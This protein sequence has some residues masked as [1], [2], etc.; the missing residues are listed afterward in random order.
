MKAA[1]LYCLA[2][3]ACSGM[4]AGQT[5][6]PGTTAGQRVLV[7]HKNTGEVMVDL[8]VTDGHGHIVRRL[9]PDE[10]EV[11]DNGRRQPIVS[12]RQVTHSVDLTGSELRRKGLRAALRP[13]PFNLTVMVFDRLGNYGRILARNAARFYIEKEMG[14]RDYTAVYNIQHVLLALQTFTTDKAKLLQAVQAA[15]NS[16]HGS[17]GSGES[18]AAENLQ[19]Q[20]VAEEASATQALTGVG[21]GG[22]PPGAVGGLVQA[23]MDAMMADMLQGAAAMKVEDQSWASLTALESIVRVLGQLPGRKE[24]LY[25]SQNIAVNTN[26]GFVFRNLVR[27]ANRNHVSI[28]SIDT[29]GLTTNFTMAGGM[30]EGSNPSTLTTCLTCSSEARSLNYS[31]QVSQQ[32]TRSG[33]RGKVT[34]AEAKA[35]EAMQNI[36]Y[37]D[38][39]NSMWAL[40][41]STGGFLA[42]YT[43]NLTPYMREAGEDMHAHYELSY[44]P[45]GGLNGA[46]HTIAIRVPGHPG[47]H[48]RAR[49]GYY[50][51]PQLAS[52]VDDYA[53]PALALLESH[54]PASALPLETGNFEFPANSTLPRVS[55]LTTIPLAGLKGFPPS[56]AEIARD[57][58]LRGKQLVRLV[59]LQVIRDAKQ[60]VLQNFSQQYEWS[61]SGR[62]MAELLRKNVVFS[63]STR[64]P[65]GDYE[66]QTVAYEP[67]D[68]AASVAREPLHVIAGQP[69]DVRMSSIVVVES[70]RKLSVVP[71][72]Y[73]PLN[74]AGNGEYRRIYPNYSHVMQSSP[75]KVIGFY[76]IVY[77]PKGL[78]PPK[79]TL[80]FIRNDRLYA[81]T[82]VPLPAPDAHGRIPYIANVPSESLAPGLYRLQAVVL[83]GGRGIARNTRFKILPRAAK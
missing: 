40:A 63:R 42:A 59:V 17:Y 11:L 16:I 65:Q 82:T 23:K 39:L 18:V 5:A 29:A 34:T 26:T 3:A 43:N 44:N 15:T 80:T 19:E 45:P 69:D 50:A 77:V 25:F 64:L 78:P 46:Y 41:D 36:K 31:A 27:A 60:R 76:F 53:L 10:L 81:S 58:A 62:G 7:I 79:L 61:V 71:A 67:G 74:Y 30:I 32:Q 8:V 70:A 13:Q 6:H 4:A 14:S 1:I 47:W 56:A 9:Q 20:S 33:G 54:R 68:Q 73:D 37:S 48:V 72:R 21:Q 22:P 12:F 52:P 49:R 75:G 83:A 35:S 51:L 66:V 55:L 24:L 28:Y 2:A 38:R 57:P